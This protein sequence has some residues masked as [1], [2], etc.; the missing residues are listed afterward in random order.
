MKWINLQI[1]E[2]EYTMF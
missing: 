2:P 1:H